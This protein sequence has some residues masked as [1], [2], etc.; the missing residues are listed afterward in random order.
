VLRIEKGFVSVGHEADGVADPHDLGMGWIV[1]AA[2]PD[3]VGR[4]ALLRNRADPAPRPQLVGLLARDPEHVP[5]EGAVVLA[6]DGRQGRGY[7]T[8][9]CMSPALRRS[10]ALALVAD[11]R[12]LIG[13]EVRLFAPSGAESVATVVKPVFFDP[14]GARM[15]G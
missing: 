10:V 2:K 1:A 9:S 4:Q 11:G 12:R 7:V 3:F 15:R 5:A 13:S 8:A 6:E 14:K